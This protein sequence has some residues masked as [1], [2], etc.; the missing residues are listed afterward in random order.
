VQGL[1]QAMFWLTA[2]D[3]VCL[4]CAA[5][6]VSAPDMPVAQAAAAPQPVAAMAEAAGGGGAAGSSLDEDL[7]VSSWQKRGGGCWE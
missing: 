4:S 2:S 6:L 3:M 5:Q 1:K 7:Q